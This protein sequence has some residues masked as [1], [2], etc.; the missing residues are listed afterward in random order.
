MAF[1]S[2]YS[3]VAED[4]TAAQDGARSGAG[5]GNRVWE[6]AAAARGGEESPADRR[7]PARHWG[8]TRQAIVADCA[9]AARPR[10]VDGQPLARP[11]YYHSP[12][13]EPGALRE[14]YAEA[15]DLIARTRPLRSASLRDLISRAEAELKR[16]QD[17]RASL[18]ESFQ[19]WNEDARNHQI[20][21][22]RQVAGERAELERIQAMYEPKIEELQEAL[23]RARRLLQIACAKAGIPLP[24]ET[25]LEDADDADADYPAPLTGSAQVTA[26]LNG[27]VDAPRASQ[28]TSSI[29]KFLRRPF[30][31]RSAKPGPDD[32]PED[33]IPGPNPRGNSAS[34]VTWPQTPSRPTFPIQVALS[35]TETAESIAS[36]EGIVPAPKGTRFQPFSD[37]LIHIV[38][39]IACGAIFGISLGILSGVDTDM[40]SLNASKVLAPVLVAVGLG[41]LIYFVMGRVVSGLAGLAAKHYAASLTASNRGEPARMAVWFLKTA[42]A[43]GVCG[44]VAV[45]LL[46]GIE[47]MVERQG[48]VAYFEHR[49]RAAFIVYGAQSHQLNGAGPVT[50]YLIAMMAVVPFVLMHIV[51]GWESAWNKTIANYL[52]G[53]RSA[54][55]HSIATEIHKGN[56]A[57]WDAERARLEQLS[58]SPGSTAELENGAADP[59]GASDEQGVLAAG[60]DSNSPGGGAAGEAATEAGRF[61]GRVQVIV[62]GSRT[63]AVP[64]VAAAEIAECQERARTAFRR[65]RELRGKRNAEQLEIRKRIEALESKRQDEL[66][67]WSDEYKNRLEDQWINFQGAVYT[68]DQEYA[69]LAR[70][71]EWR[72]RK[73]WLARLGARLA[74]LP[75]QTSGE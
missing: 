39:A 25:L 13:P 56:L 37:W 59:D 42:R 29:L 46:A 22:E 28:V 30:T 67:Q 63:V 2:E 65:L 16:Y 8:R 1:N 44:I 26:Q 20:H 36:Q 52:Q 27:S 54:Q 75:G 50:Y 14:I 62:N 34:P 73:G 9:P 15:I 48:I 72:P 45:V 49:N 32:L 18:E 71:I 10:G 51:M 53:R 61:N 4:H 74:G 7:A 17:L 35:E 19:G 24:I 3:N 58:A 66:T 11:I 47:L 68:F 41:I 6:P 23:G 57:E 33:K 60:Q 12:L 5:A 64:A 31:W 40:L 69:R 38:G 70:L 55:M 43:V 21:L